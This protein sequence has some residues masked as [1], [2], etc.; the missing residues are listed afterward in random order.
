MALPDPEPD[1]PDARPVDRRA[2][3]CADEGRALLPQPLEPS[4]VRR[5]RPGE[6]AGAGTHSADDDRPGQD[7][8]V[9][10]GAGHRDGQPWH[11]PVRPARRPDEDGVP[12][13]RAAVEPQVRQLVRRRLQRQLPAADC[14]KPAR[15]RE[16]ARPGLRGRDVE[17]EHVRQPVQRHHLRRGADDDEGDPDGTARPDPVHDRQRRIGRDDAAAPDHRGLSGTARRDRD[18]APVRGPLVPG[19]RIVGLHPALAVLRAAE[20]GTPLHWCL[21]PRSSWPPQLAVRDG[22]RSS[23]GVGIQPSGAGQPV[24]DEDR[25]HDHRA[26]RRPPVWMLWPRRAPAVAL[27]CREQPNGDPMHEPGLPEE[28][29]RG[30][31]GTPGRRRRPSRTRA[32]STG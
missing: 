22:G 29:L 32:C 14:R 27:A 26:R 7:R 20:R 11:L 28:P 15:Q 17:P 21:P 9:H 4:P 12:L 5:V 6:P 30:R 16:P 18:L 31:P 2:V 24:R 13:D 10:R 25:L 3:Q 23:E 1:E 8:S 19:A